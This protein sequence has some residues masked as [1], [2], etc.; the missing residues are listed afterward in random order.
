MRSLLL[1]LFGC[2]CQYWTCQVLS[3][4]VALV[5]TKVSF[6]PD[7]VRN[8]R[9]VVTQRQSAGLMG[10]PEAPSKM[11]MEVRTRG[12]SPI[13]TIRYYSTIALAAATVLVSSF[14]ADD[15]SSLSAWAAEAPKAM[16]STLLQPGTTQKKDLTV[17]DEVGNLIQKYY[18]D[19]S[20]NG[21]VRLLPSLL[22]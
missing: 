1:I 9:A 14:G 8:S 10:H 6:G 4:P 11:E 21:Q 18:I 3:F 13:S 16:E 17:V 19:R 15:S 20:F 5:T 2:S 12:R 22:L 7:D